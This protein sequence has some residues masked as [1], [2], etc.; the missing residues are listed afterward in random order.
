[1]TDPCP[2]LSIQ[3]DKSGA[4]V[5]I[6]LAGPNGSGKTTAY[7]LLRD[8]RTGE[9]AALTFINP[10]VYAQHLAEKQGYAN[11]NVLPPDLKAVTDIQAG[12]MALQQREQCLALRQSMVIETT[13]S[14]R[15]T[16][17]LLQQARTLGYSIRLM[18]ICLCSPE[19]NSLRI[20]QRVK[21]GGHFVPPAVVKRRCAKALALL[22]EL[23]ACA[24]NA[25]LIDNSRLYE[26]V[27]R[28]EGSAIT[29]YANAIWTQDRLQ[30]LQQKV[31]Q[32]LS[33]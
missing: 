27:L 14:S 6:M 11:V 3:P 30:L 26:T 8:S 21:L 28:K 15:G 20:E 17:R 4:P 13:A 10:D 31:R 5:L 9:F 16:V 7:E 24:D 29:L 32:Y 12:K 1:M 23:L 33:L 2:S 25:C 22:P 18:F 19:L